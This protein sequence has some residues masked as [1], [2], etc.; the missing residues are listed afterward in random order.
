[1]TEIFVGQSETLRV[2]GAFILKHSFVL[3]ARIIC[4]I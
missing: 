1:M 3:M 2:P 4:L